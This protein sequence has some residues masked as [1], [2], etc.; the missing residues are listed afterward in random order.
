MENRIKKQANMMMLAT[1]VNVVLSEM[2]IFKLY[3][4]H[5]L[6]LTLP[7]GIDPDLFCFV[8]NKLWDERELRYLRCRPPNLEH[9]RKTG[10]IDDLVYGRCIAA[11]Q[12]LMPEKEKDHCSGH[13]ANQMEYLPPTALKH[14]MIRPHPN[15]RQGNGSSYLSY[16]NDG[17]RVGRREAEDLL[18]E[19]DVVGKP[20][21]DG[22]DVHE[23]APGEDEFP[24]P[25]QLR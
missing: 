21:G 23:V 4:S 25:C 2:G 8:A 6:F 9:H 24:V 7:H 11:S 10:K 5:L 16:K 12:T 19:D 20:H 13:Y 22:H 1:I 17:P 14:G 3:Q 15:N 18:E